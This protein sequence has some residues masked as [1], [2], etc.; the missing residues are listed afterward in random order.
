MAEMIPEYLPDHATVGEKAVFN[1]LQDLPAEVLC[2]YEPVIKR[3]YP[4][5]IVVDPEAGVLVI[6]VKGWRIGW[7][8]E[9]SDAV[10]R[11]RQAGQSRTDDH[12]L[13]Q[14]RKYQDR[15]MSLCQSHPFGGILL[16]G[17]GKFNFA[18]AH[19]A[20]LTGI[21]RADLIENGLNGLFH[22]GTTLCSDEWEAVRA[23][24]P[25]AMRV[26]LKA[27]CDPDIPR[28]SLTADQ[29]KVLRGI[30]HPTVRL[31][32]PSPNLAPGAPADLRLLDFEQERSARDMRSG[33]RVIYGVA[34]S[35][36]TVI[37]MARARFLAE[38]D[39]NRRILL[40][41]Y[42]RPL[43]QYFSREFAGARNVEVCSFG[44]WALRQGAPAHDDFETFGQGLLARLE[45]GEGCAGY[46][47][48]ILID[49]GQDF[50]PSWFKCAVAAL[51]DPA[52]SDL[53]VAYDVSQNL[54]KR[55]PVKWSA[56]GVNIKGG[57]SG[58]RT[59]R[60]AINYR[61][62]Y[63]II[64]AA[65]S[66]A[67]MPNIRDED[68]TPP[69]SVDLNACR[70]RGAWPIVQ[71][72]FPRDKLIAECADIA[73]QLT[74]PDG[75]AVENGRVNAKP[76]EIRILYRWDEKGLRDDLKQA[77]ETRALKNV[78]VGTI[79]SAKGLQS[80]VVILACADQLP[81]HFPTSSEDA[82]RA[83]LYVALTRGEELLI[84]LYAHDT[85]YIKELLRNIATER[86]EPFE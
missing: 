63:E 17:R 85:P 27:A 60:L 37:L 44:V 33:H 86:G 36:K 19:L 22:P 10:I 49:E 73:A 5:F 14:A 1:A 72:V 8:E 24:G 65:R 80:K 6:E 18:F 21:S 47:D 3:R 28:R 16:N 42:N 68:S 29:A 82:E 35:G 40:L 30:I 41:C 76:D 31:D 71:K 52:L 78:H 54:Y 20:I 70:R 69:V 58:S 2:F 38:E 15:L 11:L 53:V 81:S 12:P 62:T 48:T 26:A 84:V 23:E 50:A 9:A 77:L 34:G 56:L 67:P 57:A 25:D 39:K 43:E 75:Y 4:D 74:S 7:I 64:A 13:R 32:K 46:Y 83:L 45:R 61:N 79:H 51:K 55:P 66:F 59:T